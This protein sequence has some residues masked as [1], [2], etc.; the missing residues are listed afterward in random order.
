[1][2][3]FIL[4]YLFLNLLSHNWIIINFIFIQISNKLLLNL[5]CLF[6]LQFYNFFVLILSK[7]EC[8]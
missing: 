2:Y 3:F 1:M 6:D 8:P 4:F 7:N 5:F